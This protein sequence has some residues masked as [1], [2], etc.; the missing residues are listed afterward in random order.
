MRIVLAL[1]ALLPLLRTAAAGDPPSEQAV[2]AAIDQGRAAF[3]AGSSQE[4]ITQLQRAIGMIQERSAGGLAGFLPKRD[5][6]Q[7]ELSPVDTQQGQWGAGTTQWQWSQAQR[8]YV[9]KG[10]EDG[11]E[12]EVMISNSPQLVEAQRGMLEALKSPA[13]R[14]MLKSQGGEGQKIDFLDEGGWIGMIT[15]EG[16]QCTVLA[17]HSKV[18]V[19]IQVQRGDA[20]LAREFWGAMDHAGLAAAT[21]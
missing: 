8:R 5:A 20:K 21:K 17:L 6:E 14:E 4:A 7:W 11:P 2:L 18:M 1:L 15:T 13:M 19:Q 9:K 10:A 16:E 3:A 12:V